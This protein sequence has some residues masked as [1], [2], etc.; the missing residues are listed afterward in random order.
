MLPLTVHNAP[1]Q[2]LIC[3]NHAFRGT[4]I[5]SRASFCHIP[6]FRGRGLNLGIDQLSV[7]RTNIKTIIS[8]VSLNKY[9]TKKLY[10]KNAPSPHPFRAKD[11]TSQ[12]SFTRVCAPRLKGGSLWRRHP[13]RLQ[14]QAKRRIGEP[15]VPRRGRRRRG[16]RRRTP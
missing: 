15:I 14:D 12:Y 11:G 1:S 6:A 8:N 2:A 9:F 13:A 3:T 10:E 7:Y 4:M 5:S 16:W